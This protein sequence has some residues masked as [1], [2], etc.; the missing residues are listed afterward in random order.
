LG[1]DSGQGQRFFSD[2]LPDRSQA[3]LASYQMGAGDKAAGAL[4]QPLT[5]IYCRGKEY[6]E[7]Q[8][9]S[10][11]RLHCLALNP[12]NHSGHNVYHLLKY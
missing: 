8:F 2:R 3:Y 4:K 5:S 9:D 12:S 1:F 10:P 6:K 7:L 11:I